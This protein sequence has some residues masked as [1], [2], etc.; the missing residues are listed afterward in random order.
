MND[1]DPNNLEETTSRRS[2]I[3][4]LWRLPV[5]AVVLG[6]VYGV[7]EAYKIQF[8][9]LQPSD[10][11]TFAGEERERVAE[12]ATLKEVWDSAEFSYNALPAYA[13]RLPNAIPGSLELSG[14]HYAAFSRICT[15]QGCLVNF[16]ENTELLA[17]SYNY[18]SKNPALACHCHF[19]VF[20]VT[21]AGLAVSGPAIEPLPRIRLESD[22]VSLFAT[23]LEQ[24]LDS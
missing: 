1:T 13:L 19:S 7:Y 22:G 11:P 9:K 14:A 5:I 21:K 8:R 24:S 18:R 20:D 17:V 12:L 2:F 16:T 23:G 15:H 10:T 6:G 4:W 3:T